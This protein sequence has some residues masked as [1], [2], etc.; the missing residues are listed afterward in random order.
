MAALTQNREGLTLSSDMRVTLTGLDRLA[1]VSGN[2]I[3]LPGELIFE[4]GNR[5]C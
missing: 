1:A 4:P 3:T 2:D 5:L